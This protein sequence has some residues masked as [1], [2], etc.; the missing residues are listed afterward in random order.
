MLKKINKNEDIRMILYAILVGIMASFIVVLYRYIL[1]YIEESLYFIRNI[2]IKNYLFLIIAIFIIFILAFIV[3]L[4]KKYE[5]FSSGS[6]IPQVEAE[7]NGYISQNPIKIIAT[8]IIGASLCTLGGLSIGREGPSIQL[9]AMAGKL[10]SSKLKKGKTIER[11]LITCGAGA[12]LAAAFNAPLSGVMFAIE[13][14]H[15]HISRKLLITCITASVIGDYISKLFFG[16]NTIFDFEVNYNL[17]IHNY[18]ILIILGI[19]LSIFAV[20]YINLMKLFTKFYNNLKLPKYINIL[21]P[22]V[23]GLVFLLFIPEIIG[24]GNF[25]IPS[26]LNNNVITYLFLLFILKLIFSLLSFTSGV[27]GGIFFPILILG[28]AIGG[29]FANII[30]IQ[31]LN[32]FII[33]S[34]AGFLTAIVRAPLTAIILVFEMTGT[35]KFLLPLVIVCLTAYIVTNYIGV[36]PVYD[37]LM[38]NLLNKNNIKIEKNQKV[39]FT[40]VVNNGSYIEYKKLKDMSFP[41]GLLIVDLDR[42][43]FEIIPNGNTEIHA[44]DSLHILTDEK[45]M[46]NHYKLIKRYCEC[47]NL[48]D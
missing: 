7:L 18:W 44:G 33:L 45:N 29:I 8:K 36:E 42:N 26:I 14:V 39:I 4:I 23:L 9:G 24:G 34:M 17:P 46:Y 15:R 41:K 11:Y 10:V 6:G 48:Y 20:L 12:G 47:D 40:I 27:P 31:L 5:P 35:F 28:A 32:L 22:F 21:I 2:I 13:E 3:S 25:L 16:N 19:I 1:H 38:K 30:D 37:Y 43:G